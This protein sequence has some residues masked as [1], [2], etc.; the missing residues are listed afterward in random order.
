MPF[1]F[2]MT[3]YLKRLEAGDPA[4]VAF[5][6]RMVALWRRLALRLKLH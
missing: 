3:E 2:L 1:A 6:D 4:T 5:R